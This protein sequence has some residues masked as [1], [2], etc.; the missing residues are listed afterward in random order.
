MTPNKKAAIAPNACTWIIH[1]ASNKGCN[2]IDAS[3]YQTKPL[4]LG[5][6]EV[7]VLSARARHISA[8]NQPRL[9]GTTAL[10]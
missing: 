1:G 2:D 9:K 8:P 6:A 7:R 10:A 4:G 3:F 5:R